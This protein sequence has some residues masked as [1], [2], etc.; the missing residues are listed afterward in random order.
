MKSSVAL[1]LNIFVLTFAL[2]SLADTLPPKSRDI[3]IAVND[4]FIPA[5]FNSRTEAY[6]VVSGIFPNTCYKWKQAVLKNVTTFEH[7]VTSLASVSQGMCL[8]VLVP[9]SKDIRL[10]Q[11]NSGTHTLRFVSGDGTYLEKTMVVE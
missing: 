4:V 1:C 8:M 3:A 9:F 2:Q 7:E 11:L 5:G 6:V 10:G